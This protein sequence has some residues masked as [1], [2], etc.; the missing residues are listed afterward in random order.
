VRLGITHDRLLLAL[1]MGTDSFEAGKMR[2]PLADP[3][4]VQAMVELFAIPF[5]AVDGFKLKP[6]AAAAAPARSEGQS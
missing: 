1:N 4:R 5:D 6:A 2:R 3:N